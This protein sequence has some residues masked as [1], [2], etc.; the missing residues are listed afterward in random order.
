MKRVPK[1]FKLLGHTIS[2]VVQQESEWLKNNAEDEVGDW[3]PPD[4]LIS[5]VEQ[6]QTLLMHAFCHELTHALLDMMNN[7]LSKDEA[8]VDTF[9]GL[10]AQALTTSK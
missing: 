8:F 6:D 5:L 10:L 3:S 7:D 1:R 9:A 4:L 2:V